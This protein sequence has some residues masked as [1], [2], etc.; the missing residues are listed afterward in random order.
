MKHF[1]LVFFCVS[2]S[3]CAPST[4]T[5]RLA[6]ETIV[7]ARSFYPHEAGLKWQYLEPGERTDTPSFTK[8]VVGPTLVNEELLTLSRVY[9]RGQDTKLFERFDDSGVYLVREDRP[10]SIF[11]YAPPM[12]T[13]PPSAEL[14]LGT[15]WQGTSQVN[16]YHPDTTVYGDPL[17]IDYHYQ[18]IDQRQVTVGEHTFEVYV[19][20]F[21]ATQTLASGSSQS[22]QQ[23]VWYTPYVGEI[24][25]RANVVLTKVNF[26]VTAEPQRARAP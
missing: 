24:K 11:V 19:I 17:T 6:V 20:S 21:Q 16:V 10:G 9:G 22:I 4:Q 25:T 7:T 3:A 1:L 18:V 14:Q 23:E 15:A 12:Q 13:L 8:E 26:D 5:D 2:L